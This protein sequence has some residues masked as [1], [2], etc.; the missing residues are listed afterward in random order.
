MPSRR[1]AA[2]I[3]LLLL[4]APLAL[5]T[6]ADARPRRGWELLGETTV[7]DRADH[8]VVPVTARRGTFSAIRLRVFERA[9][10]FHDLKIHFANGDVEDVP[11]RKVIPA[12][13]ESRTIDVPGGDRVIRSIEL[14]Y[15]AQ[16]LAGHRAR[17]R[18]FGQR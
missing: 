18:V 6:A 9:V 4:L 14:R 2:G 12:G 10:Q 16:S 13:G 5:P 3:A 11:L 1:T 17:V 7:T 15:D 8:D